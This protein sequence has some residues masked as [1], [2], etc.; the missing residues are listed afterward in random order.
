MDLIVAIIVSNII[1]V[2]TERTRFTMLT[3]NYQRIEH[4]ITEG[5]NWFC[6]QLY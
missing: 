1:L 5:S 6:D 2:H 4:R 3:L